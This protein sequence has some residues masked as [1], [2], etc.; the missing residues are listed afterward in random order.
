MPY[1][2][3][4]QACK[5]ARPHTHLRIVASGTPARR[6]Y[7]RSR[8]LPRVLAAWPSE[9]AD[10]SLAGTESLVQ[11]LRLALR[12]ERQRGASGHWSYD[13]GRHASLRAALT[14]EEERL[15]A[16]RRGG[17]GAKPDPGQSG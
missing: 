16:L 7:V 14:G 6:A 15:A 3:R 5:R 1:T 11:R 4:D 13:L 8:D 2:H 9:I 12:R 10:M 17:P